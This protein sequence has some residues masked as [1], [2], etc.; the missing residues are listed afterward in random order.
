MIE[1]R[2]DVV[3]PYSVEW[4]RNSEGPLAVLSDGSWLL[5]WSAFYGGLWDDAPAH[6]MGRWSHDKG[7]T[8]TRDRIVWNRAR[9]LPKSGDRLY[10]RFAEAGLCRLGA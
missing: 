3:C 7:E 9:P 6:I 8:D 10:A 1:P 5:A 2:I 4:P